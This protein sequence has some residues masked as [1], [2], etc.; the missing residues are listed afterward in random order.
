MSNY[1]GLFIVNATLG[2]DALEKAL[3]Y[4]REQITKHRGTIEKTEE[5]GTKKLSYRLNKQREGHY[6]LLNFKIEPKAVKDV[7]HA[8]KMNDSILR[9]LITKKEN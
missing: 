2:K 5:M 7:E 4:I 3:S 6:Y 9:V 1:E 8:Y